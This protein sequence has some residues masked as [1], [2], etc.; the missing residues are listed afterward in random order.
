M[1]AAGAPRWRSTEGAPEKGAQ[2][3]AGAQEIH[4]NVLPTAQEIA[5]GL[6]LLGG[7]VNG[8]ERAGAI[9]HGELTGIAP[10]GFNAIADVSRDERGR[11]DG[12][13]ECGVPSAR[14][15]TRSRTA[16][17]HS[18]VSRR[19]RGSWLLPA[20][21]PPNI[22]AALNRRRAIT[23]TGN[24]HLRRVL[25]ESAW[26]DIDAEA[27]RS[28]RPGHPRRSSELTCCLGVRGV[29]RSRGRAR[30]V[31]MLKLI[32]CMNVGFC[33]VFSATWDV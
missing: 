20:W 27:S 14:A 33:A 8:G 12:T 29:T 24:T 19:G 26:H 3:V 32:L 21:S 10:I 22:R 4:A 16:R 28:S 31:L 2:P 5:G 6:F 7:N 17:P 13:G 18:S 30:C 9:E 23:K 15:A 11:D 25:V 1:T